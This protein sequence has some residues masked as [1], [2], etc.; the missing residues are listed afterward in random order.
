M[1]HGE[2]IDGA[3]VAIEVRLPLLIAG[4]MSVS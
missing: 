2:D 4:S 1:L 3:E